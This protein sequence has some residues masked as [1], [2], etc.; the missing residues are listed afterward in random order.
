MHGETIKFLM[1]SWFTH[2]AIYEEA[3]AVIMGKDRE[4]K[5]SLTLSPIL[6][7]KMKTN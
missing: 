5:D 7:T 3:F 2:G 1:Y 4:I 6:M